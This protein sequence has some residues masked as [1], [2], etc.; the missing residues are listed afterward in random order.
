VRRPRAWVD[1]DTVTGNTANRTDRRLTPVA[2]R[3][4]RILITD[5]TSVTADSAARIYA[6]N[7]YT[8]TGNSG[9]LAQGK[10]AR[11]LELQHHHRDPGE[12]RRRLRHHQVVRLVT[13]GEAWLQV[14]LGR[15]MSVKRW[16]VR[17]AAYGGEN[18]AWNT[19]DFALEYASS[20][21]GPWT[22]RD[23]VTGNTAA[24]TDRTTTATSA[25]YWRTQG[26]RTDPDHR[27]AAASTPWVYKLTAHRI[28]DRHG[29]RARRSD[30]TRG[31]VTCEAH[32]GSTAL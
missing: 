30:H 21:T 4:W 2:A 12:G 8:S 11:Q 13:N 1:R 25:R 16:V 5:P 10:P 32:G 3:W 19:K 14:D 18:A 7:L 31:P 20:A 23:S 27:P 28:T 15:A 26:H 22:H 24:S 29:P 17:H 9:D 6:V